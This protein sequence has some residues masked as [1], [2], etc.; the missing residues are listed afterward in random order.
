MSYLPSAA[1]PLT[2][3]SAT[4]IQLFVLAAATFTF[5]TTEIQPVA[6][7]S[8]MAHGL[9]VSEH[10][11]GLLMTAYA[12]GAALTAIPLTVLAACRAAV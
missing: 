4:A 5:V 1:R 7:L 12:G 8:P 2:R 9:S 10:T 6:L 11:V 3:P